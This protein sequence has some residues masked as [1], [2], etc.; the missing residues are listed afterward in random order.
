[1]AQFQKNP[2]DTD[3]RLDPANGRL[4]LMLEE[5]A[6]IDLWGGGPRGEQLMVDIVDLSVAD[7]ASLARGADANLCSIQIQGLASGE[8]KLEARLLL[9]TPSDAAAR[10]AQW[11]A[12]PVWASIKVSV[13]GNA[14]RQS[15]PR[16]GNL[17]YGSTNPRWKDVKWTTMAYSGCGPTSLA[18]VMDYLIRLDAAKDGPVGPV[19]FRGTDPVEAMTFTS[20]FGRAADGAGLPSGTSGPTM[21]NNIGQYWPGYAGT[22]LATIDEATRLLRDG[23]PLLFLCHNCTTR[24][25]VHGKSLS[26][27]F[28][29]HFMVLVGVEHDEKTYW[30]VDPSAGNYKYIDRKQLDKTEI[31]HIY[32]Q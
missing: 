20:K 19:S 14:Y 31:W 12:A 23:N 6:K 22:K 11:L 13:L 16:W 30:I 32:K 25:M 4:T 15:G 24:K 29:G 9:Q 21:V 2:T 10:R 3:V 28:P 26:H 8:T 27:T 17:I 18:I 7:V 1:M 5:R